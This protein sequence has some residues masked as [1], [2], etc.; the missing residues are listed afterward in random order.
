MNIIKPEV[1]IGI[2]S[3][4]NKYKPINIEDYKV[5]KLIFENL[6][7]KNKNFTAIDIFNFLDRNPKIKR[8]NADCVQK[9]Y[10]Y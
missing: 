1:S 10:K 3:L 6:Y 4:E 8:I 7:L 2:E 5:I 9:E